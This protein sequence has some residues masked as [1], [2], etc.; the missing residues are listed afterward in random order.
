MRNYMNETEQ[1]LL[2]AFSNYSF[3]PIE[4]EY[5][6]YYDT[7]TK[8]CL[9]KTTETPEGDFV[10]VDRETYEKVIFCPHYFIRNGKPEKKP[11]DFSAAILLSLSDTGQATMKG[12]NM[13]VTGEDYDGPVE[14]WSRI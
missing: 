4:F 10:I 13:F 6:I 7:V 8:D 2:E 5:R 1:A 9:F 12:Y 11:V 3:T 14:Y